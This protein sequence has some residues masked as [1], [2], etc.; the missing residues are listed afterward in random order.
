MAGPV[1]VAPWSETRAYQPEDSAF[2]RLWRAFATARTGLGVALL[3][4]LGGQ[5]SIDRSAYVHGAVLVACVAYVVAALVV[6]VAVRA[7]VR[8]IDWRWLAT[9]GLDLLAVAALQSNQPASMNFSPLFAVPVLMAAVLGNGAMAFATAA[10]ASLLMLLDGWVR[11]HGAGDSASRLLQV[12][13][14]GAGYFALS[15][16]THQLAAR[17]ARAE[18]R[19]RQG[20]EAARLQTQ[21]NAL[22]IE[23]LTDGILV[24][25]PRGRV[26]AANPTARA[27]LGL[28][29][30]PA[31]VSLAESP[32]WR[33]LMEL[34]HQTLA[35]GAGQRRD[36]LLEMPGAPPQRLHV[37][38]RPA[39][40]DG[41]DT[42]GL[43]V[44]FLQDLREMEARLRTEKL[45]AMG[46]MSAAVAHEIRNPL[47][48]ISQANAL[49][50]E[51]LTDPAQ[52]Q[53]SALVGQNARRL[54]QIVEEILDVARAQQQP[55]APSRLIELDTETAS[56]CADWARQARGQERLRVAADTSLLRVPFEPDHLR[57]LLVNLLDNALRHASQAA[58][59]IQVTT[60]LDG[61]DA[62]LVVWSDGAPLEP[63][64]QRHLFEP[65]FSS[66][67]R[68]SGLGLYI[69]RELCARHGAQIEYL[70]CAAPLGGHREGN[71]FVVRFASAK[72]A[73]IVA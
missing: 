49:L 17:L 46:R 18:L 28:A 5:A 27:L 33:A 37:R 59:A 4:L 24:V 1:S 30:E 50:D 19:A 72:P 41:Q 66:Q 16:L 38:T 22:V 26:R 57:R 73:T 43:C 52:R 69:C 9:L 23:A 11:G 58:D 35:Q 68:S 53:L 62:R 34:A 70:R 56:A 12:G 31:R 60:G 47:A 45:A 48:A 42:D 36:I 25:D 15:F 32:A 61:D 29:V 67:S 13:L 65:F 2:L 54:S 64:V 44:M 39:A 55:P 10:A 40:G 14:T 51:D 8:N 71:A 21:V 7:P 63:A 3:V 20:H 6:R